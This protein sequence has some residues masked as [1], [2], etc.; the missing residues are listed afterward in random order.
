MVVSLVHALQGEGQSETVAVPFVRYRFRFCVMTPLMLPDYAGSMIRGAF[1]RA[2]RKTVCMTHQKDCKHCPLYRSCPYTRL[3]ETPPPATHELQSFSQIPNAYVIEPPKWGRHFY[4]Q[5]DSL[6][7]SVVLFGQSVNDLPLVIYSLQRAF[8]HD[9]GHGTAELI[10]VDA[11]YGGDECLVYDLNRQNVEKHEKVTRVD[12]PQS[13]SVV[14]EIET[15]MRLQHE[16]RPLGPDGI[17][18]RNFMATLLRRL[19]LLLEFHASER[20]RF[21]YSIFVQ[22]AERFS[23]EKELIWRD[24]TR[25]SSRQNQKMS[26]GGVVGKLHFSS[27]PYVARVLLAAGTFTHIGKNASF[28]LGKYSLQEGDGL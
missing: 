14:I 26:L 6:E 16:G 11:L 18:S 23:L 2:L 1:G 4:E 5:G 15:P 25:Y 3:F 8:A 24:W 22:E 10:S 28:G 20:L 13:D 17:T 7:F 9:V 19:S 27:L 21:D 12:V